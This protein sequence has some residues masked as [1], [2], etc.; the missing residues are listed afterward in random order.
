[1][2]R[3]AKSRNNNQKQAANEPVICGIVMPISPTANH[4]SLHWERVQ[5]LLHRA[6]RQ[7]GLEPENVW[8]GAATDRITVRI[9]KSLFAASVIVCDIS[10]LNPN[11]MLELGMRLT[12]R[13][14]TVVVAEEDGVIPFDIADFEVIKYP[15]DL[16]IIEMEAFFDK[17]GTH[18]KS[19][20]DAW[21]KDEYVSFIREIGPIDVLDPETRPVGFEEFLS[22]RLNEIISRIEKID[23]RAQTI[24]SPSRVS[25]PA[26][27]DPVY[28]AVRGGAEKVARAA[29]VLLRQPYVDSVGNTT[30]QSAVVYTNRK[31]DGALAD[32]IKG[33]LTK[34]G[35][36]VGTIRV[37]GLRSN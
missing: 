14:P 23:R 30:E 33:L 24:S 37:L 32:L 12:S 4:D 10:E 28:V 22:D 34:E 15:K 2:A 27:G 7:A 25:T 3:A 18:L 21:K 5:Q 20:L 9:L 35:F 1:M 31:L 36:Q 16:N 19:K 8:A 6:V 13:R 17:F 11:V 26:S 29:E